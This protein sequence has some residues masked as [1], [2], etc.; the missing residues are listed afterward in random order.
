M[1]SPS[2]LSVPAVSTTRILV[3][4]LARFGL[5]YYKVWRT[6]DRQIWTPNKFI[7]AA[8]TLRTTPARMIRVFGPPDITHRIGGVSGVFDF[9]D[10]NF[11]LFRVHDLKETDETT[12]S[13]QQR[14]RMPPQNLRNKPMPL[15]SVAQFW[16][17]AEVIAF[18]V[19]ASDKADSAS[20]LRWARE[21]LELNVD[22]KAM[23]IERFGPVEGRLEY[24]KEYPTDRTYPFF[25]LSGETSWPVKD[26]SAKEVGKSKK[27]KTQTKGE[28]GKSAASSSPKSEKKPAK[29]SSKPA[30]D[31]APAAEPLKPTIPTS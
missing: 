17:S 21:R 30:S 6:F 7:A 18:K 2:L 20:F 15:P 31:T 29:Q 5:R 12:S 10:Q 23:V 13:A 27:E 22:M 11:D 9:E 8:G 26:K 16:D 3:K 1:S 24:G 19:T 4:M 28:E 14:R 25:T